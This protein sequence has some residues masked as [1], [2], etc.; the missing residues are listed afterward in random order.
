MSPADIAKLLQEVVDL[1]K[2]NGGSAYKSDWLDARRA[3]L[4]DQHADD[5]AKL[6][7]LD[8]IARAIPGMNGL[9]DEFLRPPAESQVDSA[10]VNATFAELVQ[11]LYDGVLEAAKR[12]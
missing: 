6:A 1:M 4:E 10:A 11:T 7:V 2:A 3:T 8:E 9:V 12:Q 5:A